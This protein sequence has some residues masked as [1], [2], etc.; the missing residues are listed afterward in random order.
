MAEAHTQ[1]PEQWQGL[2]ERPNILWICTDQQ[3]SDTLGCYGNQFVRTPAIDKLA[4]E[5]VLFE[6]AFVQNPL[7]TPSRG[8]FLTGRYPSTNRLRQNGQLC[9]PDIR[10]LPRMLA[11]KGYVCGLAGKL[12]LSPCDK[13][14]E[15]TQ[16]KSDWWKYKNDYY[17]WGSEKRIDD[18]YAEFYWN[19][20]PGSGSNQNCSDYNRWVQERGGEIAYPKRDDCHSVLQ[21][22][23]DELHQTR[24]AVDHAINFMQRHAETD[25][26]WMFSLN[27]FDPHPHFDPEP[28]YLE[29]YLKML[30]DIPLPAYVAGENDRKPAHHQ[31]AHGVA[32]WSDHDKK[33]MVAAYWAMC[34]HIDAHMQRLM[35]ALEASG[36]RDN[37]I[38]MF[39]S[40]HGELLGDHNKSPK[41]PYLYDCSVRVPL[42]MSWPGH[43]AQGKRVQGLVELTDIAPTINDILDLGEEASMQGESL[44]TVLESDGDTAHVRENVY[45]EY[46]NS[47][48]HG[49]NRIYLNM[50]RTET[51]KIIVAH[52]TNDGELYDLRADPGEHRNL[53]SDPDYAA[54]KCDL[55]LQL[56]H[57]QAFSTDPLPQRVGI[58]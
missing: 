43:F 46:H 34:D 17:F 47:N 22:M 29:R 23:P 25:Y 12:H 10:I 31:K 6:Q 7:C 4:R 19:H 24:W 44:L 51:H 11:D 9:P 3:R 48:P 41:G 53:W 13:R 1:I 33:M 14:F 21:G 5:G 16:S 38:I 49:G 30:D 54:I 26:P 58:Y 35:D 50:L 2:S 8:S 55:L 27:I 36:Q 40:D 20:A 15:N 52:S 45:C 42:I 28:Q 57:R 56:S 39:H 32:E 18:G 37:T